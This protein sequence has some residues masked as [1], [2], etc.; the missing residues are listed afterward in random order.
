MITIENR[1]AMRFDCLGAE[2]LI[3]YGETY[4]VTTLEKALVVSLAT[5]LA[6]ITDHEAEVD[7]L[8]K[9]IENAVC[10][11]ESLQSEIVDLHDELNE[12]T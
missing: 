1:P 10:E 11:I 8:V 12:R 5:T 3:S 6:G 4:A 7:D 9:Q 2:E